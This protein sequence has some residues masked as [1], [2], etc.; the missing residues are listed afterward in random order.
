MQLLPSAIPSASVTGL[1]PQD[2]SSTSGS[3]S[4]AASVSANDF[5]Q[6]LVT[7]MRNQDPTA[8]TDPN[9]Y[10]NQLVQ[11][12]CL[13]QLIS[14]NQEL[15]GAASSTT[16][17]GAVSSPVSG[18]QPAASGSA[19]PTALGAAAH[20]ASGNLDAPA[21]SAAATRIASAMGGAAP[22]GNANPYQSILGALRS[23]AAQAPAPVP[24][25]AH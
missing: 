21:V 15:G 18:A 24:N 22:A 2:T 11:V 6:L 1:Q 8:N 16:A 17:T 23:R 25:P 5:L 12:N 9:E 4:S 19:A 3:G 20:R 10:I 7:E 13:E 14:I